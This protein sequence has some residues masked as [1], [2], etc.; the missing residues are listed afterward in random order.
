MRQVSWHSLLETRRTFVVV[1]A[2][3]LFAMAARGMLDPDIWWHLR[4]GQLIL[5]NHHLFRTDPYSFTR[6]GQPWVNH[7]WLFDVLAFALY[8]IGG[9]GALVVMFALITSGTFLFVFFRCPGK[10]YVAGIVTVLGAIASVSSWGVRPQMISLL[11]ATVFLLLLERSDRYPRNLWWMVP[12]TIVWVNLHAGYALGIA[13]IA[14]FLLGAR[15]ISY[16]KP[17]DRSSQSYTYASYCSFWLC[18]VWWL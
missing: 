14:L 5:D 17:S 4:T 8:R 9:A 13:L 16:F 3:G 12:L 7:E 1:L 2:L 11:L 6:S 10:P 15:L 18:A